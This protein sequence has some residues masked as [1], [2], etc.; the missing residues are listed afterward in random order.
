MMPT[1]TNS[2]VSDLVRKLYAAFLSSDRAT[3]EELL[4]DEF[5]FNSPRDDHIDKATFFERCL[6]QSGQIRALHIEQIFAQGDEAFVRYRAEVQDGT[7]FRN[8]EF[9]RI[10]GD[11]LKSVDV[12]FGAN[13]TQE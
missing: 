7:R 10:E 12:Y 11:K 4:S 5:T 1:T 13:I 3:L 2:Q 8:T 9:L 6:T